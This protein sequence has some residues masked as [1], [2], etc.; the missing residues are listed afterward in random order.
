LSG[1]GKSPKVDVEDR[2]QFMADLIKSGD[3]GKPV[4]VS[5]SMSGSF[6]LPF[7]LE[8]DSASCGE[9]MM[10]Y[11][12][13]AP[14]AADSFTADSYKDCKVNLGFIFLFCHLNVLCADSCYDLLRR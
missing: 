10:A 4:I 13:I 5:P 6:A 7:L 12:P 14:P 8:P 11:V 3:L 1:F 9:R 2:G